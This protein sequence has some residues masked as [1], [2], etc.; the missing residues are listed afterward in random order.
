MLENIGIFFQFLADNNILR[1]LFIVS[2]SAI[3]AKIAYFIFKRPLRKLVLKTKSKKDDDLIDVIEEPLVFF[4]LILGFYW[5]GMS[6]GLQESQLEIYNN[7]LKVL[8]VFNVA[9]LIVRLFDLFVIFYIRPFT[10]KSESKLDD[11]LI[12]IIRKIFKLIIAII[13]FIVI[14]DNFGIDVFSLVAGLGIGGIALAIAAKDTLANILGSLNIF[15][16]R[17]FQ[18]DDMV[19]VENYI[20]YVKE[21]GLRSTKI[22][23]LDGTDVI[24]PNANLA[25]LTIENLTK[26]GSIKKD[27]NIDFYYDISHKKLEKAV[28]IIKKVMEK[29]K[30]FLDGYYVGFNEF[31]EFGLRVRVM[32]WIKYKG[33][34]G[35]YLDNKSNIYFEIKKELDK[36]KIKM[37]SRGA[38]RLSQVNK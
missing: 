31:G 2:L 34:F 38:D 4:V 14:L 5:G 28:D 17:P 9:Y 19:K 33:D 1:F 7:I 36:A 24:I 29:N 10:D 8:I 3:A 22:E 6:L 16:D 23:T 26:R 21:V 15:A 37:E 13:A 27:I 32:H 11:Q 20:G 35:K 25:N 12:P 30:K 18:V